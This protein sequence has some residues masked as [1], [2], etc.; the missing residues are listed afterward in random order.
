MR[1]T[2]NTEALRDLEQWG[3]HTI[4]MTEKSRVGNGVNGT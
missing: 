1:R 4:P 2:G 3:T